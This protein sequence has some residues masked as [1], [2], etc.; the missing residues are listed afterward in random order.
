MCGIVGIVG[1]SDVAQRLFDGLKRQEL[2][3][4]DRLRR[5]GHGDSCFSIFEV[6]DEPPDTAQDEGD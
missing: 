2:Q 4:L 1:E 6:I 5:C 3:G